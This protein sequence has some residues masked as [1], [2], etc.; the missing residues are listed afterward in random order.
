[1]Q[2]FQACIDCSLSPEVGD[3]RQTP[4]RRHFDRL[5][6]GRRVTEPSLDQRSSRLTG[7]QVDATLAD[8][9]R[10]PIMRDPCQART[11]WRTAQH[12]GL[13]IS[14]RNDLPNR[15]RRFFGCLQKSTI[16]LKNGDPQRNRQDHDGD[17]RPPAVECGSCHRRETISRKGAKNQ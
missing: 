13:F 2:L 16:R 9:G 15:R 12:L 5:V 8:L 17:H 7:K 6:S 3:A 10:H 11:S 14:H 1:M 4:G